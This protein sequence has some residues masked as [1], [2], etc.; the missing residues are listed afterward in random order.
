MSQRSTFYNQSWKKIDELF[1]YA[2]MDENVFVHGD[3]KIYYKR[4]NGEFSPLLWIKDLDDDGGTV[5]VSYTEARRKGPYWRY[6]MGLCKEIA[7]NVSVY[8]IIPTG[9]L[10]TDEEL[11][12]YLE[13]I[14][15]SIV[16]GKERKDILSSSWKEA[17]KNASS[18][19]FWIDDDVKTKVERRPS[20][21][22]AVVRM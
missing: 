12:G 17:I 22:W 9:R 14:E 3:Y 4:N 19:I 16:D 7:D 8:P 15:G 10:M 18:I 6:L 21:K 1:N 20:G 5:C 2:K 13:P 11:I